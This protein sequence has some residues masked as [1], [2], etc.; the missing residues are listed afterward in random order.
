[1]QIMKWFNKWL[2]TEEEEKLAIPSRRTFCIG[3][4]STLAVAAA[5]AGFQKL[6]NIYVPI[7]PI[8]LDSGPIDFEQGMNLAGFEGMPLSLYQQFIADLTKEIDH[9]TGV[10][11]EYLGT[12]RNPH[13]EGMQ[14]AS[15]QWRRNPK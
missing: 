8:V 11:S 1:M 6:G 4:L 13:N 7:E 14:I 12:T 10:P 2:T 9:L 15:F 5:P 3:A